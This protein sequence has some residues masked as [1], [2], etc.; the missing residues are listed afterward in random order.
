[1]NGLAH[2][3]FSSGLASTSLHIAIGR[4]RETTWEVRPNR[5][6]NVVFVFFSILVGQKQNARVL[7]VGRM[8]HQARN[9]TMTSDI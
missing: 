6:E 7:E 8:H 5:R 9:L 3:Q 2:T 4:E 1:M